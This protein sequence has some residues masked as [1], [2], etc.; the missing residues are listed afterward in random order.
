MNQWNSREYPK[1]VLTLAKKKL[2]VLTFQQ[3][4]LQ[5]KNWLLQSLKI[6][7]I[8][9]MPNKP[10]Q[11]IKPISPKVIVIQWC[12]IQW[13]QTLSFSCSWNRTPAFAEE[14][15][16]GENGEGEAV[17][18]PERSFWAKY[19]SILKNH[20]QLILSLVRFC[21]TVAFLFVNKVGFWLFKK[22][23]SVFVL[24]LFSGCIWSL[25]D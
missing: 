15:L 4:V 19:V 12:D 2:T 16:G 5:F 3:L 21:V 13:F 18:P 14:I 8:A 6:S 24:P 11:S 7:S 25:W 20:F 17:M 9:F 23:R 1:T 22:I 10:H